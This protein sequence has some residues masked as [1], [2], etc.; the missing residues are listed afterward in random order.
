MLQ[1]F[2]DESGRGE[3]A[4]NPIFV[5]G[6]YAGSVRNWKSSTDELQKIMRRK[7]ALE[8]LKGAEAA[9]LSG[10]FAGWTAQQ[11]NAKLAQMIAVLR[12]NRMIA[13][14]CAV[15]YRDLQDPENSKGADEAAGC[16][17]FLSHCRVDA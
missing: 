10:N 1:V 7:P 16:S 4:Q 9:S 3:T 15:T 14:S 11:R 13:I 5:A 6:G 8:Y 17:H 12:K 2:V